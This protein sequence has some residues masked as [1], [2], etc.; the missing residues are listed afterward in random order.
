MQAGRR[1]GEPLIMIRQM[2]SLFIYGAFAHHQLR[3]LEADNSTSYVNLAMKYVR[4]LPRP[5]CRIIIL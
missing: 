3:V 2:L 4:Y 1:A 5:S